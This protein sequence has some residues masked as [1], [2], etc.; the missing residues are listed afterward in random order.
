[1]QA[2]PIKPK[3]KAP[4]TKRLKL[5][6]NNL[7]SRFAF[8]FNLCRFIQ[9]D[10]ITPDAFARVMSSHNITMPVFKHPDR[11]G[12]TLVYVRAQLEQLQDTVMC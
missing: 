9:G 1:V 10:V 6:Y 8:Q 4:G 5:S 11:Q 12:L 7:L 3:L 2:E